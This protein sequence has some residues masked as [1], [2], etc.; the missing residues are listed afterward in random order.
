MVATARWRAHRYHLN[1][2][3]HHASYLQRSWTKHGKAAFLFEIIEECLDEDKVLRE[4]YYIDT[5]NSCYNGRPAADSNLGLK[6]SDE[7]RARMSIAQQNNP[8][9]GQHRLGFKETPEQSAARLALVRAGMAANP[10]V[11]IN[12]GISSKLH[13]SAEPVP[14]GWHAGRYLA[15][16]HATTLRA[17]AVGPRSDQA[18]ANIKAGHAD[19][20]NDPEKRARMMENRRP[21]S[22]YTDGVTNKRVP[23]GENP[24]LGWNPG[25]TFDVQKLIDA[26]EPREKK[27]RK[28]RIV[29][30]KAPRYVKK[31][32][33]VLTTEELS[34]RGSAAWSNEAS[35]AAL[36]A[37][38]QGKCWITD[39]QN[40]IRQSDTDPIPE[41]WRRGRIGLYG[42]AAAK[43][44][45]EKE[46]MS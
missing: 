34:R 29:T 20:W 41:G 43:A 9:A 3:D 31:G 32:R 39:G 22:W 26:R 35:R 45:R 46:I 21:F 6:Y 33:P 18:K 13:P 4:Q 38:R 30:V 25:R 23:I 24:P 16:A 17:L 40:N 14:I 27:A 12:D 5:L 8:K 15:D 1:L 19:I 10:H 2:G 37:S 42:R 44:A 36:I 28:P 7:A 11:W